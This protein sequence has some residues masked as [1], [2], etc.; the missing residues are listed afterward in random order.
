[1]ALAR[2]D[3]AKAS[4]LLQHRLP[5]LREHLWHLAAALDLLVDARLASGDL[6][7]AAPVADRLAAAAAA[8]GPGRL[9]A[10]AA[11]A[12]GGVAMAA[13][14]QVAAV[15]HLQAAVA[16]WAGIGLPCELAR[17]RFDLARALVAREPELAV[18]QARRALAALDRIGAGGDAGSVRAPFDANVV[19]GRKP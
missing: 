2:G 9:P 17:T 19:T 10:M 1:L 7:Q 18:D 11:G 12:L 8:S 3:G 14:D 15:E 4:R 5:E 16:L 6:E 13:G